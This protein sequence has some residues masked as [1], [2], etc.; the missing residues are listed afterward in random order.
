MSR[1]DAID[2]TRRLYNRLP[3]HYRAYDAE[4][5][6]AYALL[7]LLRVVGE[8]AGNLRQDL[9]ALW[10]NFFIETC[11]EWVVP[12]IGALVGTN[13]LAQPVAQSNRLD[14]WNT[15]LWRR[16]KGTP[17]MLRDLAEAI[18][19]WK[20]ELAEFFQALGWSQNVNHLRLNDPLTPDLRSVYALSLLGRATDPFSHA[21]DF[22]AASPLDGPRVTRHSLGI[23]RFAWETPGRY[24]VKNLGFFVRRLQT[25]P[26]AGVT[27]AGAPPGAPVPLGTSCFTFDPLDRET[28]LFAEASREPLTRQAFDHAPWATFGT[29]VAVRQFGVLLASNTPPMPVMSRGQTAFDFGGEGI[30]RSLH[31]GSGL[32][33]PNLRPFSAT[34]AHFILTA[35]WEHGS[36]S[37]VLGALSTLHAATG[38]GDAYHLGQAIPAGGRLVLTVQTGKPGSGPL[39]WPVLPSAPAARFPATVVAIRLDRPPP[40][41]VSDTLYVYLPAAFLRPGETKRFYVADDGSSYT[42]ASLDATTLA[43]AAEGQVYPPRLLSASN[44]PALRFAALSREPGRQHAGEPVNGKPAGAYLLDPLHFGPT[45]MLVQLE[46]FT[47]VPQTLGALATVA[48]AADDYTELSAPDPWPA[49]SYAPSLAALDDN[50][51]DEGLLTVLLKPLAGDFLPQAELVVVSR[52]GESLLIY[53]PEKRGVDVEGVRLLVAED[54]ATYAFPLAAETQQEILAT[55]SYSGLTLARASAGQV[56]PIP[57]RWPLQQR[58][59]VAIDLCRCERSTLLLP[60]E[61]GIDPEL[62]RFALATGDPAID[63]G[64]L[65]VDYVEAFSDRIGARTFDRQSEARAAP[66]RLVAQRGDSASSQAPDLPLDHIHTSLDEALA[67]AGSDGIADEIIEI[68]DSS[69]YLLPGGLLFDR[70]EV[71]RLTIRA[72]DGQR[73]CLVLTPAPGSPPGSPTLRFA[74]DLIRLALE[75]LLITGG[76]VVIEGM[77]QDLALTACT[78]DPR[79]GG[80]L[81][82]T[83]TDLNHRAAYLLCRCITGGLRLGAGVNHLIVA[84]SIVDQPRGLAIGGLPDIAFSP[85]IISPPSSPPNTDNATP[86]QIVQLERV[87]VLGQVRCEVLYA[88]ECLLDELAVVE[89]RQAGCIRFS[90]YELG[91]VLP[92]RYQC[93]PSTEQIEACP[94]RLRCLPPRFS[95]RRFGRPDY[96]QLAAG[97]PPPILTASELGAEAGAFA[98]LLNQIRLENLDFKVREFLPVGL[99]T[100]VIAE[101]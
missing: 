41:H 95:S 98:G 74:S 75:G 8:Q 67:L 87:T 19:G 23:G 58:Q 16:T 39:G 9:D 57:D 47:G 42:D 10:D 51:P 52:T 6:Q 65:S 84:D 18:S 31:P 90:R 63:Q 73:P 34:G 48:Q 36:G 45:Q 68:M 32:R 101:T 96:A 82:A 81:V 53:L 76:Q 29:D 88:S 62:G 83:D 85:P 72:A 86:A 7:A 49:F 25:F 35:L 50:M 71:Q 91:S 28:P 99:T 15:V 26:M 12:Y 78:L 13:L 38:S 97:C 17:A 21:A 55:K 14:V 20:V 46:L 30:G 54:G 1:N 93:V 27:P 60:G 69:T 92:R 3:G 100:V 24:Q 4:P 64:G 43:R 37:T 77:V 11:E 56:L 40:L 61:L 79:A 44:V 80:G 66:T 5:E 59:P 89:D 33:L 70:P 2:F 94:P 22:K